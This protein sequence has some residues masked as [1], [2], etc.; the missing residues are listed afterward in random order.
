MP[1][2]KLSPAA[3]LLS[4]LLLGCQGFAPRQLAV[5]GPAP[6]PAASGSTPLE[7]SPAP[8]TAPL[9]P[10]LIYSV[11][12]GDI[13]IQR[14]K[15]LVAYEHYLRAARASRDARLAELATRAAF[16]MEDE[17]GSAEAV[18]LWL[19]LDPDSMT[20]RQL[21]ALLAINSGNTVQ[22]Q[23]HL[24]KIVELGRSTD[25]DG[26]LEAARL[27]ARV[28][29]VGARMRLM[30]ELLALDPNKAEA[31]FAY[32][33]V[34]AST[35][36]NVAAEQAGRRALELRPHWNEVQVFLVRVLLAEDKKSE[37]AESLARFVEES[38][39]D[40][41]LRM[42]Y[43]RLLVEQES[44]VEAQKEFERVL[45][46]KPGEP[47]VLLTLGVLALQTKDY[48][49]AR[50]YLE[51]L[52]ASGKRRDDALFY[53]G[54]LDE[55]EGNQPAALDRYTQIRA[56]HLLE[57]QI[58]IARIYAEQGEINRSREV[59]QQLRGNAPEQAESLYLIEAE[60]L[61]EVKRY[62]EAMR[63]YDEAVKAFPDNLD[64]LYARAL[65]AAQIKRV[66]ILERDLKKILK[67]EPDHADA[68]NALGYTLAD[69]TNRYAEALSYLNRAIALKP[70]D[71]AV[72]D[73]M[74][75]VQYRMGNNQDAL[76]Y[77]QRA[78]ALLPDS[79]ISAHLGEVLWANGQREEAQRVWKEALD[80]D[81]GSEYLRQVIERHPAPGN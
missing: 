47:G 58:R 34:A 63:V 25:G 46:A 59:I 71:A 45:Q 66:D 51:E 21:A 77:L 41:A 37:A 79:E 31:Q 43:A 7:P 18:Q 42:A 49:A 29:D 23:V 17:G 5:A 26:Y 13:A 55:R 76:R 39:D 64:L 54:Q 56:E 67:R 75:W 61:R 9:T 65:H 1:F 40:I 8:E 3:A 2:R 20:A 72:L 30:G 73:S 14:G 74:G 35:G 24:R 4:V 50:H 62:Q 27:L 36:D 33:I 10:D 81:P 57:A 68:L 19:E 15:V 69:Q 32:A 44:Y 53:L 11:L 70:N 78:A 38:P 60:I 22:A 48:T 16:S 12:V 52:L 28:K 80:R 6:D